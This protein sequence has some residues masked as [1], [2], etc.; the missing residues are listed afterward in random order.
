MKVCYS[1]DSC[2]M[3]NCHASKTQFYHDGD[4]TTHC[5]ACCRERPKA[6]VVELHTADNYLQYM[7]VS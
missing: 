6:L 5:A 3:Q 1:S 2:S 4:M 7:V